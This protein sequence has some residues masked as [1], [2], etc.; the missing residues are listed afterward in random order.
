MVP[1]P[2][3]ISAPDG[4]TVA[5]GPRTMP[6]QHDRT[7][8]PGLPPRPPA[9][10]VS[11][12]RGKTKRGSSGADGGRPT[13]GRR[14]SDE[15]PVA[16]GREGNGAAGGGG[17]LGGGGYMELSA[18]QGGGGLEG[19]AAQ[20]GLAALLAR[21]GSRRFLR[22]FTGSDADRRESVTSAGAMRAFD[23]GMM[24]A[25]ERSSTG[26]CSGL[27]FDDVDNEV[28]ERHIDENRSNPGGTPG[29]G[30]TDRSPGVFLALTLGVAMCVSCVAILSTRA[31]ATI[32]TF[33]TDLMLKLAAEN[34]SPW[35]A[36]FALAGFNA[37][38][39]VLAAVSVTLVEQ[40]A[41]GSGIPEVKSYLNGRRIARVIHPRTLVSK[42]AGLVFSVCANLTVGK[43][44]PMIHS[45][46]IIGSMLPT[47]MGRL[48]PHRSLLAFRTP[49]HERDFVSIGCA[50]GV[51]GAFAAPIG[52]VLF[53]LEEAAT[54][55]HWHSTLTSAAF[56]GAA[57]TAILVSLC[58]SMGTADW[59]NMAQS[60]LVSFGSFEG[61][62]K[63]VF[64]AEERPWSI[65]ELP[66]YVV[67]GLMG[68]LG[69]A[70][71]IHLNVKLTH[72]RM[73]H[74]K[75]ARHKVLEAVA[76][77]LLTSVVLFWG[78]HLFGKCRSSLPFDPAAADEGLMR[79][80][81][82]Q[83]EVHVLSTLSLE[84]LDETVKLLF[85][86][87]GMIPMS[88]LAQITVV[89]A[90]LSCLTYGISIPSGMFVPCIIVG[91][92]L[93]RFVGQ[94]GVVMSGET[95][96]GEGEGNEAG[97]DV[98]G[99]ALV[100]AAACL[101]GVTRVAISAAVI[102]I[103][104][105]NNITYAVPVAIAILVAKHTGDLFNAG[106]Y[107]AHIAL[108]GIAFLHDEL[109]EELKYLRASDVATSPV[110][111]L[112]EVVSAGQIVA[113]LKTTNL[114]G[115]P[116]TY[117][118]Q[119]EHGVKFSGLILRQ[120]LLLLLRE[121]AFLPGSGAT[122]LAA[123]PAR[124]ARVVDH[125][126]S[127][128]GSTVEHAA[129]HGGASVVKDTN[130]PAP[131]HSPYVFVAAPA[132]PSPRTPR[133]S[134]VESSPMPCAT[135]TSS[136]AGAAGWYAGELQPH[137]GEE[138]QRPTSARRTGTQDLAAT[139]R[140]ALMVP[141]RSRP[142]RH[143]LGEQVTSPRSAG[144]ADQGHASPGVQGGA[145]ERVFMEGALPTRATGPQGRGEDTPSL[146]SLRAPKR[147]VGR[148]QEEQAR[149][150]AM[151][152]LRQP[153]H[154]RSPKSRPQ[155]PPL[156]QR[157]PSAPPPVATLKEQTLVSWETF[158]MNFEKELL[159]DDIVLD[160][161]DEGRL[162]D[163]TPYMNVG[164]QTAHHSTYVGRVYRLFR[165]LGLRHLTIVD[166]RNS[167]M[168]LITR[169]DLTH[170]VQRATMGIHVNAKESL[171]PRSADDGPAP[172]P[173]AAP[174]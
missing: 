66:V 102:V 77:S 7:G 96:V 10:T 98:G 43:E 172:A 165:N 141:R 74:V 144:P 3:S 55:Q 65:R 33:K 92:A 19:G 76:V 58:A 29:V 2:V 159:I 143:S 12:A 121:R 169:R 67:L 104:T 18:E 38:F 155:P 108:Q 89:Y 57:A 100:G 158:A 147:D 11:T 81:C 145:G 35:P 60:A 56:F 68:G 160:A 164:A 40:R 109:A 62:S 15:A 26:P 156:E 90:A 50:C 6:A 168:G 37:I 154:T 51:A 124:G 142:Q 9:I 8:D 152:L 129:A 82:P 28:L 1:P 44:G 46:A 88:E 34:E 93:G 150:A 91:A 166:S 23:K 94:V 133:V 24:R 148:T 149:E 128:S 36:F 132:S 27:D 106:L 103:E 95:G 78:A 136:G 153:L 47:A 151:V 163:L 161:E 117:S 119:G 64:Y 30:Y 135:R 118:V 39:V 59:G 45:G 22:G 162:V 71:F 111:C 63:S 122:G 130:G 97:I 70:L 138:P 123:V 85:H 127:R 114:N 80:T 48:W 83:G 4:S 174:S 52:G 14:W 146:P 120:Q 86:T 140:L 72:W 110:V 16:E 73:A 170:L 13:L 116:V 49:G 131:S 53:V 31:I 20:T 61:A 79:F 101:A 75:S 54:V 41:K 25:R 69:G 115:F 5:P 32:F 21:E 107:D 99:M 125:V 84:E 105:T 157:E 42:V 126:T 171:D 167:V 87:P 17:G 173:A 134:A 113:L 137:A 112:P 139:P